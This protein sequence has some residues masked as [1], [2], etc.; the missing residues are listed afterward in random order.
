MKL[1]E[2]I[3]GRVLEREHWKSVDWATQVT[4][5]GHVWTGKKHLIFTIWIFAK[6]WRYLESWVFVVRFKTNNETVAHP[7]GPCLRSDRIFIVTIS[8]MA[9]FGRQKSALYD[10]ISPAAACWLGRKV[11]PSQSRVNG[12]N[13]SMI[14]AHLLP[15]DRRYPVHLYERLSLRAITQLDEKFKSFEL[16]AK[17]NSTP[18]HTA[19]HLFAKGQHTLKAAAM[20][21]T[22]DFLRQSAWNVLIERWR[23]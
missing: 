14:K 16:S 13:K 4:W 7:A 8:I 3:T 18:V 6:N 15:P 9:N 17:K 11:A 23:R 5:P 19:R 2:L 20:K 10:F 21:A 22:F 12:S 1:T